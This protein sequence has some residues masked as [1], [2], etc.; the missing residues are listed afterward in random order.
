ME[1][2]IDYV[3]TMS[4]GD[5]YSFMARFSGGK[6]MSVRLIALSI[7]LTMLLACMREP[8]PV[9]YSEETFRQAV[10][11]RLGSKLLPEKP[12]VISGV[13]G[14]EMTVTAESILKPP[15][16]LSSEVREQ[17]SSCVNMASSQKDRFD[18]L[19]NCLFCSSKPF[20]YIADSTL[21]ANACFQ[22]HLGNCFA[23]TN[24]MVG[25]ARFAKLEAYYMLVEDIVGNKVEADTVVLSNHII[26]GVQIGQDRRMVDFV[27]NTRHYYYV[28]LLSDLEAAGLYYNN[29]AARLL[30]EHKNK[31]A[32]ILFNIAEKF[33]PDSYQIQNNIGVMM[34]RNGNLSGARSHFLKALQLARFPD[35]V[36]GNVMKVFKKHGGMKSPYLLRKDMEKARKRNPYFYL[37]MASRNYWRRN[38]AVAMKLC[39]TAKGIRRD[40]PEI[41]LLEFR[42]YAKL[43]LKRQQMETYRKLLKYEHFDGEAPPMPEVVDSPEGTGGE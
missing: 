26:T 13:K 7:I 28:V 37:S 27:P 25:A 43:G 38:Y 42:I 29:I 10:Q 36:M 3:S 30:L 23:M 9:A 16:Q 20:G 17:L 41:Y 11:D 31:N 18:F 34:L 15:F 6:D 4:Y 22:N 14:V 39:E 19:Y 12:I 33:Y 5:I 2:W 24:L 8:I 35:M 32:R 1:R 40:I 21:S